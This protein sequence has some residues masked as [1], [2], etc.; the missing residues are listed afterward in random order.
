MPYRLKRKES[1][2]AGVRR[3]AREQLSRAVEAIDR[4]EAGENV[5]VVHDVRRRCKKLRG[6]MRL[7]RSALKDTWKVENARY[8][9]IAHALSDERDAHIIAPALDGL[10]QRFSDVLSTSRVFDAREAL[11]RHGP[12][13]AMLH[14]PDALTDRL[15]VARTR[16]IEAA[17]AVER[18]KFRRKGF[19]AFETGFLR[20]Y[21]TARRRMKQSKD[22]TEI[23]AFHDWRKRAKAHWY[24]CRLLESAHPKSLKPRCAQLRELGDLLGAEQD[25]AVLAD[26]MD[27][28]QTLHAEA[29][30]TI[31]SCIDLRRNELRESACAL[32]AEL[33][34]PKPQHLTDRVRKRWTSWRS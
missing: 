31:S 4:T 29:A 2:Q 22:G 18:W 1:V 25:L 19:A 11:L 7:S 32:G 6:L 5:G 20:T 9:D 23:E 10:I 27:T 15:S 28:L 17:D 8:R 16:L 21:D 3:I 14:Q 26:R 24:H 13:T 30:S 33:F 12:C 34:S